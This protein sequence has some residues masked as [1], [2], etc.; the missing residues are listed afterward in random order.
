MSQIRLNQTYYRACNGAVDVAI[1]FARREGRYACHFNGQRVLILG[2]VL[3]TEYF[4]SLGE[5]QV[6]EIEID[7]PAE[8]GFELRDQALVRI[9]KQCRNRIAIFVQRVAQ[10]RGVEIQLAIV[11]RRAT[12]YEC[13]ADPD[14]I[15]RR[16]RSVI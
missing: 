1:P 5:A 9:R 7:E 10:S 15:D 2:Y 4:A 13:A 16:I 12:Q 6:E 3:A 11:L 8:Q 14:F